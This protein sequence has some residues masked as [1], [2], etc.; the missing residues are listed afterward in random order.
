MWG[1]GLRLVVAFAW[2]VAGFLYL[3]AFKLERSTVFR[4]MRIYAMLVAFAWGIWEGYIAIY[5]GLLEYELPL[6][7]TN[8][9]ITLGLLVPTVSYFVLSGWITHRVVRDYIPHDSEE[10]ET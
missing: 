5:G 9:S 3:R 6:A 10:N 4:P 1:I 2:L 7:V 8:G